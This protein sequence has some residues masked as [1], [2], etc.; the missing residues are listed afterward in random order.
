MQFYWT[1]QS[2]RCSLTR[3]SKFN[4][5]LLHEKYDADVLHVPAT[6]VLKIEGIDASIVRSSSFQELGFVNVLRNLFPPSL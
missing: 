2:Q 3:Q 5:N 6:K 4:V 1:N